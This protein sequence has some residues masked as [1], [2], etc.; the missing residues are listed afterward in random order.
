MSKEMKMSFEERKRDLAERK[1]ERFEELKKKASGYWK[2]DRELGRSGD[3]WVEVEVD[4]KE[5]WAK[6]GFEFV[7][8]SMRMNREEMDRA[9][10]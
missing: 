10:G 8:E 4:E 2:F 5:I 1:M 3:E 9:E 6:V 7:N